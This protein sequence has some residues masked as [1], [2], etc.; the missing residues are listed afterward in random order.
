MKKFVDNSKESISNLKDKKKDKDDHHNHTS[1]SGADKPVVVSSQ[2]S[3]TT[4]SSYKGSNEA[5][6]VHT[7]YISKNNNDQSNGYTYSSQ[8]TNYPYQQQPPPPSRPSQP[9]NQQYQQGPPPPPPSRTSQP[10]YQQGP[11]P[12]TPTRP[13]GPPPP[14]THNQQGP[15]PPPSRGTQPPPP[16]RPVGPPPTSHTGNSGQPVSLS[17][18]N[19][20]VNLEKSQDGASIGNL[21]RSFKEQTQIVDTHSKIALNSI[22]VNT[23]DG[24]IKANIPVLHLVDRGFISTI[25]YTET[26]LEISNCK[27]KSL[28]LGQKKDTLFKKERLVVYKTIQEEIIII[29]IGDVYIYTNVQEKPSFRPEPYHYIIGDNYGSLFMLKLSDE[30][31]RESIEKLEVLLMYYTTF[32]R[33]PVKE[34]FKD[35]TA[36]KI[37]KTSTKVESGSMAVNKGLISAGTYFAK[38]AAKAGDVYKNNT[39]KYEGPEMTEEQKRELEDPNS[40]YNKSNQTTQK[41]VQGTASVQKGIVKGFGFVGSKVTETYHKTDHYK[42]KEEKRKQHEAIH[43]KDEKKE[44][45]ASAAGTGVNAFKNVWSGLEEGVLISARG[46]RDASVDAKK[47]THGEFEAEKSKKTWN[48]AGDVTVSMVNV[49]SIMSATWIKAS[50]YAAAGALSYD[51]NAVQALSGAYWKGGW[52]SVKTDLLSGSGWQTRWM[53]LRNP[54]LAIYHSSKDP[55]DK[56]LEFWYL[57]TVKSIEKLSLDRAQKPY[58]FEIKTSGGSI[59]LSMNTGDVDYSEEPLGEPNPDNELYQWINSILTVSAYIGELEPP[60][61]EKKSSK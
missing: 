42:E 9:T 28:E 22:G 30:T 44:A 57:N 47:H 33:V 41:F 20:G 19:Q 27:L 50:L 5:P 39:K 8:P 12:P 13:V 18:S 43:G 53:I 25:Q 17:K 58:A 16:T 60:K 21:T 32:Y 31:D 4:T 3:V 35:S 49:V 11:P 26:I 34:Q 2:S 6:T 1:S 14:P 61:N 23:H 59:F 54:T 10:T 38:G 52:V 7:S 36:Q 45:G 15:P 24:M 55:Y 46:V 51:P 40:S 37:D 29:Q 48:S 56:P